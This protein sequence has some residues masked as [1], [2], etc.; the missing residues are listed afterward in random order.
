MNNWS[1][2]LVI[3]ILARAY[4]TAKAELQRQDALEHSSLRGD[5]RQAGKQPLSTTSR[6]M[7]M[8]LGVGTYGIRPY[9]YPRSFPYPITVALY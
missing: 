6:K 7:G 2:R 8:E 3:V 4:V 9:A 5:D 1:S